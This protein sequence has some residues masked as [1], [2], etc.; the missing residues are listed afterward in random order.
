MEQRKKAKKPVCFEEAYYVGIKLCQS[1]VR[2]D[3]FD[4]S[5]PPSSSSQIL[6]FLTFDIWHKRCKIF[7]TQVKSTNFFVMNTAKARPHLAN[8]VRK[9]ALRRSWK[10]TYF[11][12]WISKLK[13]VFFPDDWT[14]TKMVKQCSTFVFLRESI[15]C[16]N[17][18]NSVH[19]KIANFYHFSLLV[20]NLDFVD[21]IQKNSF[22]T[23]PT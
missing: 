3:T 4:I 21:F 14:F 18:L 12:W 19:L 11:S 10:I 13:K 6:T 5:S 9:I 23:L 20:G 15:L 8:P 7:L 17:C 16:K 2:S 22:I 1:H